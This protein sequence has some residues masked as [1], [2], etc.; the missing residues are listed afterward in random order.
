MTQNKE[1]LRNEIER[2][3]NIMCSL[4]ELQ[5]QTLVDLEQLNVSALNQINNH[6]SKVFVAE[7]F[8][9]EY[10]FAPIYFHGA[11]ADCESKIDA[12]KM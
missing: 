5:I 4:N 12:G 7:T 3:R 8:R 11:C 10:C 9:C 1:N 6:L 2:L